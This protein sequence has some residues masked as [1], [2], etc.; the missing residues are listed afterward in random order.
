MAAS[1]KQANE[2]SKAEK[3]KAEVN[4]L[5]AKMYEDWAA[6]RITEYNFNMLSQKYQTEQQALTE[7]IVALQAQLTAQE[8]ST[9]DAEKW[10]KLIRQYIPR[11]I[12]LR[13]S[14]QGDRILED[15]QHEIQFPA[16][17][18]RVFVRVQEVR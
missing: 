17:S 2:L 7:Q 8:Q 10:V 5:F 12:L 1:K 4:R 16:Y 14:Q 15:K 9:A 13:Y 18:A 11:N 6:G 3:R